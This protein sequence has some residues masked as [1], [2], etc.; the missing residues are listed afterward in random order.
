MYERI[1]RCGHSVRYSKCDLKSVA[2]SARRAKLECRHKV[3]SGAQVE[4]TQLGQHRSD[5]GLP[6]AQLADTSSRVQLTIHRGRNRQNLIR[7]PFESVDVRAVRGSPHPDGFVT[8]PREH[9]F[10]VVPNGKSVHTSSVALD[11]LEERPIFTS[12]DYDRAVVASRVNLAVGA[13][14]Q[15][16]DNVGVPD[17]GAHV[18]AILQPSTPHS[19]RMIVRPR[20]HRTVQS[21]D[22]RTDSVRPAS[23]L[24]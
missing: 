9:V 19:D 21:N 18:R 14:S 5:S 2:L 20:V 17:E 8:R 22:E 4:C 16:V 7:V 6:H 15:A 23:V 12:P 1:M 10:S 24:M 3:L 11:G 13:H